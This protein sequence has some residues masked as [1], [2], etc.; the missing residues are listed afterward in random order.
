D[1]AR[2]LALFAEPKR[3]GR[4]QMAKRVIRQIESG[5]GAAPIQVIEGRYGPYVS[6]GEINA[7][8]PKGSDPATLSLD[9]ARALIEARRGAPPRERR[10]RWSPRRRAPRGVSVE[11]AAVAAPAGVQPRAAKAGAP[12]IRPAKPIAAKSAAAKSVVAKSAATKSAVSK[13]AATK[14]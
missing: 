3:G 4:R 10:G 7:S 8:I 9:E 14:A 1:L 13:G 12:K 6:D 2:A 5:D 11:V